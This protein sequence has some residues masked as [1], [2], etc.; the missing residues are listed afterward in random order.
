MQSYQNMGARGI[1][2]GSHKNKVRGNQKHLNVTKNVD[3]IVAS[4]I[5]WFSSNSQIMEDLWGF[6]TNLW[7]H[8]R[9]VSELDTDLFLYEYH[10]KKTTVV[11][12]K[13]YCTQP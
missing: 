2:L 7:L 3:D 13:I 4:M 5:S 6:M 12:D 9:C 1:C 10:D 8:D 11:S